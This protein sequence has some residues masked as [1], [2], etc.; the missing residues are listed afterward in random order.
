MKQIDVSDY[1]FGYLT[2]IILLHY[3]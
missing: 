1:N 3:L 2:L